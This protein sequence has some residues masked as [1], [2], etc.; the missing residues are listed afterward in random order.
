MGETEDQQKRNKNTRLYSSLSM[1]L[2]CDYG[3][4]KRYLS[5]RTVMSVRDK[6]RFVEIF[7]HKR[8]RITAHIFFFD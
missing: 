1:L 3:C 4:L 2:M 8:L 6:T 5:T 7:I